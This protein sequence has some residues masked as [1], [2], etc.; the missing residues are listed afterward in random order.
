MSADAGAV[1]IRQQ[2]VVGTDSD[3]AAVTDFHLAMKAHVGHDERESRIS[4]CPDHL[5]SRGV[6]SKEAASLF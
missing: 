5:S 4:R 1:L 6:R 3:Q 2:Q